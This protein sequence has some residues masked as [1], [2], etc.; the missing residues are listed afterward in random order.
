MFKHVVLAQIL[1][2]LKLKDAPYYYLDTHAGIG[3]YDLDCIEAQLTGE[4]ISGFG[5]LETAKIPPTLEPLFTAYLNAVASAKIKGATLYPGSPWIA[6]QI[7][8]PQDRLAFCEL[9][10][11]DVRHLQYNCGYDERSKVFELNGFA[12]L[13]GYTPPKERRGLVLIDPPFETTSEFEDI[14]QAVTNAHKKWAT[15]I[16][17]IWYPIKGLTKVTHFVEQLKVAQIPK[18]LRLELLIDDPNDASILSGCGFVIINPPWTLKADAEQILPFLSD[19]MRRNG[20][21]S[22]R[23]TWLS[24]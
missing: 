5:R 22:W 14:I 2:Y 15:G 3:L 9:H 17:A 10:K 13:K 18:I 21:G 8:R 16:Y 23:S 7:M 19:L 12:G 6:Q 24:S 11:D 20:K 4:W 1:T